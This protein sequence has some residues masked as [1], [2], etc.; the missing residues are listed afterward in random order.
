M[1]VHEDARTFGPA[2]Q[3]LHLFERI[4]RDSAALRTE[5][6]ADAKWSIFLAPAGGTLLKLRVTVAAPAEAAGR[7]AIV[8][9]AA[10]Y[11]EQWQYIVDGGV[12]AISSLSRIN[13]VV[14]RPGSSFNDGLD[15]CVLLTTGHSP[16]VEAA[17]AAHGWPRG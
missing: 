6:D 15:A 1:F 16:A 17:I 14:T 3:L 7:F 10:R 5:L 12:L 11:A 4:E 8:L 9:D 13:A 2:P